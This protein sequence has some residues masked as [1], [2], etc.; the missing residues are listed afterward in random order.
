MPKCRSCNA[1][2]VWAKN[3]K[4]GKLAP[5]DAEPS[6]DGN[7]RLG[8]DGTYEIVVPSYRPRTNLHTS[9]FATCPGAG[10]H[11]KPKPETAA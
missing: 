2:I 11:R 1:E 8:P 4:T 6:A 7:I 10:K 9:H 5:L 3:E